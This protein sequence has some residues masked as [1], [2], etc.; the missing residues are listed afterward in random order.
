MN[1]QHIQLL[2][3]LLLRIHTVIYS[4]AW[5]TA[6]QSATVLLLEHVFPLKVFVGGIRQMMNLLY[7]AIKND[8]CEMQTC[9]IP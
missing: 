3:L 6:T 5:K 2:L 7:V 9:S 4:L 1:Q 8:K